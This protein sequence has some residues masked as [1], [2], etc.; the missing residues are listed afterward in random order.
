[1]A[2]SIFD[3]QSEDRVE[4]PERLNEYIRVASP[5]VWAIVTALVIVFAAFIVWGFFGTIPKTIKLTGVVD[6]V[7]S[8]RINTTVDAKLY[9]GKDL[10]GKEA[11]FRLPNG[12][13]GKCIVRNATDV[14]YSKEELAKQLESDFL[15]SSMAKADYSYV[16]DVASTTD[17]EEYQVMLC[18]VTII[19]GEVHPIYYLLH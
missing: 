14:P 10:I 17:L 2:R 11:T 8:D 12:V 16:L 7:V 4:S 5:G 9:T 15:A 13:T 19:T 1:M 6:T 18:E 3:V